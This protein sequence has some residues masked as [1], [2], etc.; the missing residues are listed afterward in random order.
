ML[1]TS[2]VVFTR[3]NKP[4]GL[5]CPTTR[6]LRLRIKTT[7]RNRLRSLRPLSWSCIFR[8][9]YTKPSPDESPERGGVHIVSF[10]LV[11]QSARS[12]TVEAVAG[13]RSR[14]TVSMLRSRSR[15]DPLLRSTS[16]DS[17]A[18]GSGDDLLFAYASP[19]MSVRSICEPL[20][21]VYWL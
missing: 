7:R 12:A 3:D 20:S 21:L 19:G 17:D 18:L 15:I 9:S 2:P 1:T 8:H 13:T 14:T 5:G 6:G 11:S 16:G 4:V 10:C